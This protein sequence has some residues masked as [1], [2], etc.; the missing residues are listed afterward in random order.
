MC[1]YCSH[2]SSSPIFF[3]RKLIFCVLD[4]SLSR[5]FS[6]PGR[7]EINARIV[8]DLGDADTFWF[9]LRKTKFDVPLDTMRSS[10]NRYRLSRHRALLDAARILLSAEG[11]WENS[12]LPCVAEEKLL[13]MDKGSPSRLRRRPCKPLG[14]ADCGDGP[15]FSRGENPSFRQPWRCE[16]FSASAKPRFFLFQISRPGGV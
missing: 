8:C 4:R 11:L 2:L 12:E 13:F 3:F 15:S 1:T 14:R 5:T 9:P 7:A 6:P 10:A 16:A